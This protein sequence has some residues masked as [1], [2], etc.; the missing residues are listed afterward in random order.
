MSL[1]IRLREATD[2]TSCGQPAESLLIDVPLAH[3]HDT[4]RRVRLGNQV[5]PCG[6]VTKV[7]AV[8]S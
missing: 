1:E 3:Q 4:S 7:E 6:C 5:R 2:C 8:T